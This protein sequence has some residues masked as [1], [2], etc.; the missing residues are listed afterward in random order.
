MKWYIQ[1]F[2]SFRHRRQSNTF[3]SELKFSFVETERKNWIHS[4]TL[5]F[6]FKPWSIWMMLL[7]KT[8]K[9]FPIHLLDGTECWQTHFI[10]TRLPL[11]VG[12]ETE[13][14]RASF[15]FWQRRTELSHFWEI[16][17]FLTHQQAR[18]LHFVSRGNKWI[19][20]VC[21]N[22]IISVAGESLVSLCPWISELDEVGYTWLMIS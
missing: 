20:G 1:I 3:P 8:S 14:S 21:I 19:W 12:G 16:I 10:Q 2:K 4:S 5:L 13:D 9:N 18:K 22:A 17:P 15:H 6:F 7:N 11:G